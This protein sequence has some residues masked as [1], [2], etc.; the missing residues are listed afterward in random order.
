MKR[1]NSNTTAGDDLFAAAEQRRATPLGSV[2]AAP[3]A[4]PEPVVLIDS[5]LVSES[6]EWLATRA[7]T[8]GS[9]LA[10]ERA[11][12]YVAILRA[13][14][15][16]RD[17]HEPEPLHEDL[18]VKVC[19]E[20]YTVSSEAQFKSDL[21]QLKDWSLVSERIEKERLRG[22]RDN[23]RTKFRYRLCDDAV[24]FVAWLSER[25]EH[26][27]A[28]ESTAATGN[29]LDAQIS[30]LQELR[31]RVRTVVTETVDYE[32]AGAVLYRVEQ[33]RLNVDA[34]A[35][36]LQVL[37]LRLLSF[38]AD[39]FQVS[40]AKEVVDELGHFLE[41]FGQRFS[42][43][44]TEINAV[45]SDLRNKTY[46]PRWTACATRLRDET[47][48]F[49]HIASV[50]VPDAPTALEDASAFYG[51]GG[52]LGELVSRVRDSARKV[53]GKLNAKLRE[54]ER[55]NH[56]LEDLQARLKEFACLEEDEVPYDW[57]RR[58]LETAAMRGDPLIRPS[59]EKSKHPLPK[60]AS[61]IKQK[62]LVAWITPRHV[63]EKA[64]V[65]SI[66]EVKAQRL[67]DWMQMRGLVPYVGQE[68]RLSAGSFAEFDDFP[69][70]VQV[71]EALRLGGG[72]KGRRHLQLVGR[73]CAVRADVQVD[74]STLSFDDLAL[75]ATSK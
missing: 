61:K 21:R 57:M 22:Y 73:D 34:T 24:S 12:E 32:T 31:R 47:A 29:L 52:R 64:N 53:W 55:R 66:T 75:K 60:R 48:K 40:E 33:M 70:I 37:N 11:P 17:G 13:F 2:P 44:Q 9:L 7:T 39:S 67:K 68:V 28:P 35:K 36:T 15:V 38:G 45:L 23:R 3:V 51:A 27:L 62:H 56:R 19:G 4:P 46:G 30:L 63:G 16:M 69:K 26:D 41:H 20:D 54:L 18:L 25:R 14:A 58:V 59:G 1:R 65:A 50:R 71:I 42:V 43:L 8:L 74:S 5:P 72:E 49:R 6:A 10:S